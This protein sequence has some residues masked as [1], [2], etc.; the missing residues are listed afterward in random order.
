MYSL[1]HNLHIYNLELLCNLN[2]WNKQVWNVHINWNNMKTDN[3]Y[4]FDFQM[5]ILCKITIKSL[6]GGK[7]SLSTPNYNALC[8]PLVILHLLSWND[9]C[10]R[11]FCF[12]SWWNFFCTKASLGQVFESASP[13]DVWHLCVALCKITILY[14]GL[15]MLLY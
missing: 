1:I 2:V 11:V 4:S 6:Y 14:F 7:R 10:L 8:C 3:K 9:D 5:W 13:D 15:S 12:L